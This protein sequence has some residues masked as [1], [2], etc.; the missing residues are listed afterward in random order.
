MR[1]IIL[2]MLIS[3]QVYAFSKKDVQ[4]IVDTFLCSDDAYE[5]SEIVEYPIFIEFRQSVYDK[6]EFIE[7]V[8]KAQSEDGIYKFGKSCNGFSIVVKNIGYD[9]NGYAVNVNSSD[10]EL[11]AKIYINELGKIVGIFSN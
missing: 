11:R 5:M 7:A 4:E 1:L 2:M 10:N 9:G 3:S 6:K 8:I